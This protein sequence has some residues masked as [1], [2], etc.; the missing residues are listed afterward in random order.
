MPKT[1][2]SKVRRNLTAWPDLAEPTRQ[3]LREHA[4]GCAG[5]HAELEATL[6]VV[7][8]LEAG[9]EAYSAERY[10]GPRPNLRGHRALTPAR[11]IRS[12]P[13]RGFWR[14]L[15]VALAGG[16]FAVSV[17]FYLLVVSLPTAL[18]PSPEPAES[19]IAE[20]VSRPLAGPPAI[21]PASASASLEAIRREASRHRRAT[22]P[23]RPSGL[24]LRLPSRPSPPGAEPGQD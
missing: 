2:C 19:A 21:R 8:R 20:P 10:T 16:F 24:S 13:S 18:V 23:K 17:A 22:P 5:C 15:P 14:P 7:S 6:E 11:G 4:R 1:R 12:L 9:R 3:R